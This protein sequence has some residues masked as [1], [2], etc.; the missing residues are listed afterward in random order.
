MLGEKTE[1]KEVIILSVDTKLHSQAVELGLKFDYGK[2][3]SFYSPGPNATN[4]LQKKFFV[5]MATEKSITSRKQL[6]EL[7]WG[8]SQG[9]T[10]VGVEGWKLTNE[11][12]D[13]N[14]LTGVPI[15][16]EDFLWHWNRDGK[17]L[18]LILT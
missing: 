16:D 9:S 13:T 15:S 18:L 6:E 7:F 3:S 11:L 17:K 4:P 5:G 8:G 1:M 10:A 12:P 14:K 2:L